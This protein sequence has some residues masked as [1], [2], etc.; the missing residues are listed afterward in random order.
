MPYAADQQEAWN[1]T[2][3]AGATKG[4]AAVPSHRVQTASSARGH[5]A[6]GHRQRLAQPGT[7]LRLPGRLSIAADQGLHP[8]RL[9]T[10]LADLSH[11]SGESFA[12][13]DANSLR[14]AP[15]TQDPVGTRG[16]RTLS[17]ASHP[18]P[19]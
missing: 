3:A 1:A 17:I 8:P 14:L 13:A 18:P 9:R 19:R 11:V 12:R 2:A 15:R 4:G 16:A 7:L 5:R 6:A 10:V